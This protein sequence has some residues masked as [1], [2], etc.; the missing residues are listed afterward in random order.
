MPLL[1]SSATSATSATP[2]AGSLPEL[3]L[4]A[5]VADTTAGEAEIACPTRL[6]WLANHA[7][8]MTAAVAPL[9]EDEAAFAATAP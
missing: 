7:V 3:A 2:A 5:S 6:G 9:M 1:R 4:P 8:F